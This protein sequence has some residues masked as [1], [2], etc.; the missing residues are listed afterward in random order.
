MKS[1][2]SSELKISR[3]T[4]LG[5]IGSLVFAQTL[6]KESVVEPTEPPPRQPGSVPIVPNLIFDAQP[7]PDVDPLQTI[8]VGAQTDEEAVARVVNYYEANQER[9]QLLWREANA[10]NSPHSSPCT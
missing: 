8:T 3:R 10:Q 6:L 2:D 9:L 5:L 1:T 7:G 4:S